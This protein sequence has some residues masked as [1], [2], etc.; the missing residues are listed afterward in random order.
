ML[1]SLFNNVA[2]L[3]P[4]NFIKRKTPT[5]VFPCK[6]CEMF[7]DSFFYW[8]PLVTGPVLLTI[9]IWNSNRALENLRT[10]N[11]FNFTH[12]FSE[13]V[14]AWSTKGAS[15]CCFRKAVSNN[16]FQKILLNFINFSISFLL[17]F[18]QRGCFLLIEDYGKNALRK[19]L[20]IA[21]F[22]EKFKTATSRKSSWWISL[23]F[24]VIC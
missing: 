17:A 23:V 14:V 20:V 3:Q 11:D 6:Y 7:K 21:P 4:Y 9:T 12:F 24:P 22:V 2:G 15:F 18:C 10:M 13:R 16:V 1:A 5:Q 8:T 19:E